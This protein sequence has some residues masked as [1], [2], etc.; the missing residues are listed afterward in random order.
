M[1]PEAVLFTEPIE[2][3]RA[4]NLEVRVRAPLNNSWLYL[5]GA[6]VNEATSEVDEFDIEITYYS[7]IDPEDGVWSEGGPEGRAYVASVPPGRYVM[8]L[9]PQWEVG[10]TPPTYDLTVVSRVPRFYQML[11]AMLALLVWPIILGWRSARYEAARWA[12]SDHA[13]GSG[14]TSSSDD[15]DEGDDE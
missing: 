13:A 2:L 1:S 6:L 4:G 3:D 14:S 11:L 5:D 9:A 8:R 10:K 15:D 7:G 12:E